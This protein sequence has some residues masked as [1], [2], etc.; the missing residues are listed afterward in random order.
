MKWGVRGVSSYLVYAINHTWPFSSSVCGEGGETGRAK[1]GV[2]WATN[3]YLNLNFHRSFFLFC[4]GPL[5]YISSLKLEKEKKIGKDV[6]YAMLVNIMLDPVCV[7]VNASLPHLPP[8]L[9]ISS[10]PHTS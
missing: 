9:L 4:S 8:H 3:S 7:N 5:S 2:W 6:L 10:F 1:H